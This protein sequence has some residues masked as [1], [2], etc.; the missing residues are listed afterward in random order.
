MDVSY[1]AAAGENFRVGIATEFYVNF[2]RPKQMMFVL[3]VWF[4]VGVGVCAYD[5]LLD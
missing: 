5:L 4:V 2:P 1:R 3:C